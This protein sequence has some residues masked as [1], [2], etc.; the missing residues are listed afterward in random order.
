MR[1]MISYAEDRRS[2]AGEKGPS[3]CAPAGHLPQIL[4]I[5]C[6]LHKK[7]NFHVK[8]SP[9]TTRLGSV[10]AVLCRLTPLFSSLTQEPPEE[11]WYN[12]PMPRINLKALKAHRDRTFCML[13]SNRVAN[14][15]G[16]LDFVNTRGFVYF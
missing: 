10:Y 2:G 6:F 14:P 15:A 11:F 9:E 16:A 8:K 5:Y 1:G 4:R 3:P 13:S 12:R 7:V